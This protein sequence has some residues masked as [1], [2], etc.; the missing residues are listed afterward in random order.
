MSGWKCKSTVS[1][2]ENIY[3]IKRSYNFT[4]SRGIIDTL[5]FKLRSINFSQNQRPAF[6]KSVYPQSQKT[7]EI[8][9]GH[10]EQR[11]H[12]PSESQLL[13]TRNPRHVTPRDIDRGDTRHGKHA[14]GGWLPIPWHPRD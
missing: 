3:K 7:S 6:R 2:L 5:Q 12:R 9:R 4:N 14:A 13:A 8:K 11:K 10:T 1:R